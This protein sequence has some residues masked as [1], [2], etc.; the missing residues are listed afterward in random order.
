MRITITKF[1]Y[2][3]NGTIYESDEPFDAT[4]KQ[5]IK[6]ARENGTI[7]TVTRKTIKIEIEENY[8]TDGTIWPYKK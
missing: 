4:C 6:E 2:D 7:S 1:I 3:F 8:T 5:M